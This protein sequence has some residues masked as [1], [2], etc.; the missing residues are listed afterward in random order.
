MLDGK[1]P[2]KRS[3]RRHAIVVQKTDSM[4]ARSSVRRSARTFWLLEGKARRMPSPAPPP[5]HRACVMTAL[6]SAR[7]LH[8]SKSAQGKTQS[9]DILLEAPPRDDLAA[10]R[11]HAG[12]LIL[13]SQ[14]AH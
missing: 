9:F 7:V 3:L 4:R 14:H 11:T 10:S 13:V 12:H 6:P 2:L 1:T 5:R 8:P